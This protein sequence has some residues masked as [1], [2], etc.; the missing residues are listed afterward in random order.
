MALLCEWCAKPAA[1][2]RLEHVKASGWLP[3]FPIRCSIVI[4]D[5]LLGGI[6][7]Q[8]ACRRYDDVAD[9][10]WARHDVISDLPD[11]VDG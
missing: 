3:F 7:S 8:E 9:S 4:S 1:L 5:G 6:R 11:L 2:R 10:R